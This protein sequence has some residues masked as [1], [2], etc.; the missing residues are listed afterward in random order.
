MQWTQRVG[1]GAAV[2]VLLAACAGPSGGGSLSG[3]A[4]GSS[5]ATLAASPG[6]APAGA[7]STS[8]SSSAGP[9]DAAPSSTPSSTP[10]AA[11]PSNAAGAEP[12]AFRWV[13][14]RV[15]AK[16]LGRSWR[17]GCPV[18]PRRLRAV[19][20][21]HWDLRGRVRDGVLVL[22]EDVVARTRPVFATMFARR[23]PL[24]RVRPV[25]AYGASDDRSMAANNTSA[26][27]CRLAVAAGPPVWSRHAYGRA[28]DVNPV[29]NPYLFSGRVLP[30]AGH[31][32][33]DRSRARP[34]MIRK[35]DPVLR[36]FRRAG[37]R[38]GGTFSNPDYQHFDR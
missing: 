33:R 7:A 35:G 2:V 21:R 11:A 6:G 17:S 34:G 13:V 10:R 1:G 26:F 30:P 15:T 18:G 8:T 31:A 12:R 36:A 4:T 24:Q 14:R 25:S 16:Q 27:N 37:Y 23:F 19:S 9:S 29:Q 38:W 5:E 28:I 20:L 3:S 32:Y 22:H